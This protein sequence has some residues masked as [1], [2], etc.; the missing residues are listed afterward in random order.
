MND[1]DRFIEQTLSGDSAA[2]GYLV[3]KYQDRLFNTLAHIVGCTEEAQDVAQETFLIAFR[4][5]ETFK[6]RSSLYTWLYRIAMNKWISNCRRN[7]EKNTGPHGLSGG[8]EPID[9]SDSAQ[10][11]MER[12]ERITQIRNA[13]LNLEDRH[14]S[15]LVLKDIDGCCYEEIAEILQ[16]PI[17]TVR[18]RL[19]RARMQLRLKLSQVLQESG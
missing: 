17:G 11:Q 18:S 14:R 5:L 10:S 2:F 6:R 15:V 1:D 4:K 19:H 7:R 16:V 12:S 13:I 9:S 8:H 3:Q